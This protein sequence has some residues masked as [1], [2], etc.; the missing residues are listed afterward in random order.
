MASTVALL[1]A[2]PLSISRTMLF[3][4]VLSLVFSL[5]VSGKSLKNVLAGVVVISVLFVILSNFT[6]FQ[7]ATGAFTSRYTAANDV[8]GGLEGVFVDRF[9]GGMYSAVTNEDAT[10]F[11]LGLGMGTNAGARLMTGTGGKFLISEGEWGRVVGEMGFMLGIIVILTRFGLIIQFLKMSWYSARSN[12]ILPWMLMS[13][14]ML[15]ILQGQWAQP[16]ALG[17]SILAAGLVS[18]A[19]DWKRKVF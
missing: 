10:F 14:A 18:G 17:F 5:V 4:V 12:N 16:T 6:F 11:G 2:L 8:E 7:T 3:E 15:N 1:C 19:A 9:L 13:F